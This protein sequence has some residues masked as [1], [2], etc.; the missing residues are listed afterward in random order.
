MLVSFS[1]HSQRDNPNFKEPK[2][3]QK[4]PKEKYTCTLYL[5]NKLALCQFLRL[6]I[7]HVESRRLWYTHA[8]ENHQ[9]HDLE[10]VLKE[11]VIVLE[12]A[13]CSPFGHYK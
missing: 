1:I 3:K 2:E 7:I 11:V 12:L 4:E 5:E 8:P 10:W 9:F 6:G 13:E